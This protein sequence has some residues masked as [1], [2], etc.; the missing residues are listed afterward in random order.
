M[1]R[2]FS[3][4]GAVIRG[5]IYRFFSLINTKL[6]IQSKVKIYNNCFVSVRSK[7]Q[8]ILSKNVTIQKGASLS[9][10]NGGRIKLEENVSIGECNYII[11]HK[12]IHIGKNTILGP[13]VMIYDHDHVFSSSHGVN[14]RIYKT[15]EI[16]IG[17]DCWIGANAIILKGTK[18]GN[19]CIVGAGCVL[20]GVYQDE[21]LI[22]QK[23]NTETFH[24]N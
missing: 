1:Q 16:E 22:I 24:I 18:I 4:L 19:R 14:R 2:Y 15:D 10:L 11:C 21:S 6:I 20:K 3:F 13:N 9:A 8:M 5:Q 17:E 23:R 12:S 7:G